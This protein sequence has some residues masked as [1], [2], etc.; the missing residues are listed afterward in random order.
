M[1]LDINK[2]SITITC[3]AII[4]ATLYGIMRPYTYSSR[5]YPLEA[6]AIKFLASAPQLE[7]VESFDASSHEYYWLN[8]GGLAYLDGTTSMSTLRGDLVKGSKWRVE[9]MNANPIDTDNGYH[10]QSL[11]RLFT[12][13]KY[14]DGTYQ[15]YFKIKKTILSPS[16]NRNG[17]NGLLLMIHATDNDDLYYAG[18]RVDGTAVI[19]K[20]IGG[21]YYTLSEV[22]VFAFAKYDKDS[23]PNLLPLNILLGVQVNV[24]TLLNNQVD[25][26]LSID[27]GSSGIWV[28]IIHVIDKPKDNVPTLP[29]PAHAGLR[30]DFMEVEIR[31]FIITSL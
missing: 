6:S 18:L 28:P 16:P 12:K 31:N 26:T 11:F 17:S 9:Y 1:R 15:A 27:L 14:G 4:S 25:M 30:T 13:A 2:V 19:K 8:S 23:T 5:A 20:K 22:P 7:E 21:T 10:P 24:K 3:L 29:M